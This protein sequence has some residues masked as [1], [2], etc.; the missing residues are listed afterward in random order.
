MPKAKTSPADALGRAHVKLLDDIS[1]LERV[2][3]PTV[4]AEI[5][6]LLDR[7]IATQAHVVKHFQFEERNGYMDE[8]RKHEPRL[9]RTI[10]QLED[11]HG[12]LATS[13]SEIIGDVTKSAEVGDAL[14]AK[15]KR[16]IG[17]LRGHESRENQLVLDVFN[18]DEAAED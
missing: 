7:L 9:E 17:N 15:V 16:W 11:E 12:Q 1:E 13:L 14:R 6:S 18:R 4:R 8:I 2:V 3:G 5:A 10:Q